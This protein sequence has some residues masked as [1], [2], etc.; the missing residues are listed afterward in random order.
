[1]LS[2]RVLERGE[3]RDSAVAEQRAA[4]APVVPHLALDATMATSA[5]VAQV[6]DGF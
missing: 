3:L 4:A 2:R 1:V 6:L 5:Q